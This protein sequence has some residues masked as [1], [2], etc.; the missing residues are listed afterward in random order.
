MVPVSAAIE[1]ELSEL[2]PEEAEKLDLARSVG[3]LSLVLRN[4]VDPEPVK[5]SGAT[6]ARLLAGP[7]EVPAAKP[8][9]QPSAPPA[10]AVAEPRKVVPRPPPT[11]SPPA[12]KVAAAPRCVTVITGTKSSSECFQAQ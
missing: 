7:T 5:T 9:G 4:Q 11:T 12:P 1:E 6:K 8:A 3:T 2:S 10:A